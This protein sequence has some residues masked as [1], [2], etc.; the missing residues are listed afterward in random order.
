MRATWAQIL[1]H[2]FVEGKLY[3]KAGVKS[4]NSPFINPQTS[5]PKHRPTSH[6]KERQDLFNL[7]QHLIKTINSLISL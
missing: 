5:K 6:A 3:I 7:L 2:P 1:C 4:D